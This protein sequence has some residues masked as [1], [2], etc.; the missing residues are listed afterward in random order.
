MVKVS[1]ARSLPVESYICAS[2]S[3]PVSYLLVEVLRFARKRGLFH[4]ENDIPFVGG[5]RFKG[6]VDKFC[7]VAHNFVQFCQLF[8]FNHRAVRCFQLLVKRKPL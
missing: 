7:S 2:V 6:K 4:F 3:S 5:R 1:S 8:N